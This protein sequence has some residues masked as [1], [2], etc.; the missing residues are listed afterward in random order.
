MAEDGISLR[1]GV[2]CAH[3]EGAYAIERWS[4]GPGPGR[5]GCSMGT[6]ARL[7]KSERAQAQTVILPLYPEMTVAEQER[8][9]ERLR[10]TLE[11]PVTL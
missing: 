8:V 6:C 9:V 10:R 5:C 3:R 11:V 7:Q 1:P 4:C 2:M